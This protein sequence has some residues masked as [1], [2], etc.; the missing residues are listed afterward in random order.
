MA[1][2][3]PFGSK[4]GIHK[5]DHTIHDFHKV[6][7]KTMTVEEAAMQSKGAMLPGSDVLIY[8]DGP[9]PMTMYFYYPPEGN[10]L[11][12]REQ[13][14]WHLSMSVRMGQGSLLLYKAADDV[15]FYHG[16]DF[17]FDDRD[18][19]DYRFAFVYRWLGPSQRANFLVE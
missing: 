4:T 1:Y 10:R 9:L 2:Y 15:N 8:T 5:D 12:P 19:G 6:L 14:A 17:E 16:V 3:E 11:G 18:P 7:F 13:Y